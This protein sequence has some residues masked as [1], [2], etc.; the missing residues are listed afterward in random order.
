MPKRVLCVDWSALSGAAVKRR[1]LSLIA[2]NDGN[3]QCPVSL[4]LHGGFKSKRGLTKHISNKHEWYYYHDMQ[5]I[6]QRGDVKVKEQKKLKPSTHKIP[7][8]SIEKGCGKDFVS[9]LQSIWGGSKSLKDAKQ[10]STRCMKFLMSALGDGETQSLAYEEYIDCCLGSPSILMK[11]IQL[12]IDSWGLQPSAVLSYLRGIKELCDF[13]KANGVSDSVLRL[14][15]VTEVYIRKSIVTMQRKRQMEYNRNYDMEQLIARDSWCTLAEIEKVVPFH[16][17]KYLNLVKKARLK[18][19]VLTISEI[20]YCTRFLATYLFLRVKCTRPQSIQFLSTD[21]IKNAHTTGFVDQTQ[22]KTS[23]EYI[24]DSLTFTPDSLVVIDSYINHIRPLCSPKSDC[25]YVLVSSKGTQ[26]QNVG[27]CMSLTVQTAIGKF[28]NP[29]RYRQIIE[30]ES[31]DKL[32]P[33]QQATI[34][35]DQRHTSA[36]AKR[37]YV[38]KSSRQTSLAG[39]E[40]MAELTGP[41]RKE[42]NQE[43]AKQ[44]EAV[45]S[46]DKT[47][48]DVSN[49]DNDGKFPSEL[50]SPDL[51]DLTQE[52][53]KQLEPVESTDSTSDSTSAESNRDVQLNLANAL[54]RDNDLATT[55]TTMYS[56][57]SNAAEKDETTTSTG[58]NTVADIAEI[59]TWGKEEIQKTVTGSLTTDPD[60]P[61]NGCANEAEIRPNLS[62]EVRDVSLIIDPIVLDHLPSVV[63]NNV[64]NRLITEDDLTVKKEEMD[65]PRRLVFTES[66]DAELRKGFKK[67]GHT[68]NRWSNILKDSDL[69]FHPN[70]NRDTIRTRAITLKLITRNRRKSKKEK[71]TS[72]EV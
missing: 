26:L 50:T 22:F 21:M 70:R 43:L 48:V 57:K 42:H 45:E 38:K 29:T 49:L 53:S 3:F 6:F 68:A 72:P 31:D 18:Q 63:R 69:K 51:I 46:T 41:G 19:E 56:K 11:F 16:S 52:L 9:W 58:I 66:E 14:F 47:S 34:T 1:R 64:A 25:E 40:I 5:P 24:F 2:D 27:E 33:K 67:Y 35:L 32:T 12:I 36:V 8:F 39:A 71:V 62:K 37:Y 10:V 28:I 60:P 15:A 17:P 44:L 59:V 7:A 23:N 20:V 55:S 65:E 30:T 13:R 61:S 4:C 54:D